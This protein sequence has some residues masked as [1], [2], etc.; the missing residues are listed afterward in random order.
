MQQESSA[1][2]SHLPH[3]VLPDV[4][5]NIEAGIRQARGPLQ[6]L[7]L[8]QALKHPRLF[9]REPQSPQ[10][11]EPEEP[12]APVTTMRSSTEESEARSSEFG[13]VFFV[14]KKKRGL[15]GFEDA[16]L[17][18]HALGKLSRFQRRHFTFR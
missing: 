9:T 5:R 18:F 14:G 13:A 2:C 1:R 4:C 8:V 12:E 16:R 11:E 7:L 10:L 17:V 6:W 3:T 15:V